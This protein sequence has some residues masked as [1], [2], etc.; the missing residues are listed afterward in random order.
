MIIL[1]LLNA[2]VIGNAVLITKRIYHRYTIADK[3]LASFTLWTA[4]VIALIVVLGVVGVLTIPNL[5]V[6]TS[7][8]SLGIVAALRKKEDHSFF[9]RPHCIQSVFS[10]IAAH[11]LL[12]ISVS[13]V[14]G[15][16]LVKIAHNLI[17]PTF[18]WGSL[19]YHFRFPVEWL[20]NGNLGNPALGF[21]NPGLE[22]IA[23]NGEFLFCWFIAPLRNAYIADVTS[24]FFY[25]AG[26]VACY[27]IMRK[28]SVP[29]ELALFAGVL[30]SLTPQYFKHLLFNGNDM[31][32][33]ALFLIALNWVLMTKNAFTFKNIAMAGIGTGLLLGTKST[34]LVWAPP[35][36]PLVI[37]F[38]LRH[39]RAM[40][41]SAILRLIIVFI[42]LIAFFG[43]FT[44]I[45]NAV[46]TG[47]PIYPLRYE[48]GGLSLPGAVDYDDYYD[49]VVLSPRH[50]EELL[51]H[52]SFGAHFVALVFPAIF[53][54]LPL[55][56]MRRRFRLSLDSA[57]FLA[58]P[59]LMGALFYIKAPFHTPSYAY[60]IVALGTL[61]GIY[62]LHASG[63]SLVKMR[64]FLFLL[65]LAAT[66][67]LTSNFFLIMSL[68]LSAVLF[69]LA[70]AAQWEGIRKFC[71][72]S[73]IVLS[74]IVFSA[75]V[76]LE[77]YH[78][79]HKYDRYAATFPWE[80]DLAA[81]WR[82]VFETTRNKPI[83]IAYAGS[84]PVLPLYGK[85]LH[86]SVSYV[87]VN[88]KDPKLH[89][90]SQYHHLQNSFPEWLE[91][92][93]L[94]GCFREKAHYDTWLQNLRNK[95]VDMLFIM[96]TDDFKVFPIED[97][98]ARNH[99]RI[100]KPVLNN[101][102]VR[103]YELIT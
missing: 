98:W 50:L 89:N 51:F 1:Y 14:A 31:I 56:L 10:W 24:Y 63:V 4:Q 21:G 39:R 93:R 22:Y 97:E 32:V 96:C 62:A 95:D 100:F 59:F 70:C 29:R 86:N 68:L 87:S 41:G 101:K 91:Q 13:I 65:V 58:L 26:I 69:G 36:I 55:V 15:F 9:P 12:M 64:Y 74:L 8:V 19:I 43:G 75:L 48:V 47:N 88:E 103:I 78:E 52:Q 33:A 20:K 81:A 38:A 5:V 71:K 82:W 85:N 44:Y 37:Y 18:L 30:F 92:M 84:A 25:I 46:E 102:R 34:A 76:P 99:R 16:S 17:N 54:A 7:L 83:H 2:L 45:R 90:F 72:P 60:H 57:Y 35:L 40:R 67:E 73:A 79:A 6:L 27:A 23:M 28:L 3:L 42:L 66:A 80:K 61:G 53:L 94:D 77:H 49:N 11:K